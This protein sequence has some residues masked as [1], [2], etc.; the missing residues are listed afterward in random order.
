MICHH[1]AYASG[2]PKKHSP[3]PRRNDMSQR[4]EV[5]ES[6]SCSENIGENPAATE[7]PPPQNP[8]T[9]YNTTSIAIY[10]NKRL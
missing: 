7:D 5:L 8:P 3:M 6:R 1:W 2:Q 4:I 10:I 9:I